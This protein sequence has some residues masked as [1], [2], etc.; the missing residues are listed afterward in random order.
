MVLKLRD[1]QPLLQVTCLQGIHKHFIGTLWDTMIGNLYNH[2]GKI[3][4]EA[5]WGT[6]YV[7]ITKIRVK[8][9][10]IIQNFWV[11]FLNIEKTS[12]SR[13]AFQLP[14]PFLA[15]PLN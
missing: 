11:L 6:M 12:K 2:N 8:I 4:R 10:S 1:D 7:Q 14:L 3:C 13:G 9:N 5:K 15:P